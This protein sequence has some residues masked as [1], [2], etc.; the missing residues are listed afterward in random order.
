MEKITIKLKRNVKDPQISVR[1]YV[2]FHHP[3]QIFV[4]L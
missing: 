1:G 3:E 2:L 4:S